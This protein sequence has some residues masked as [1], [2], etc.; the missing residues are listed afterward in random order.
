MAEV[1]RSLVLGAD[2]KLRDVGTYYSGLRPLRSSPVAR[3]LEP[4]VGCKIYH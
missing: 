3:V 2:F 4:L 1:K